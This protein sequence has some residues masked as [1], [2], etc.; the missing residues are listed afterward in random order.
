MIDF[1]VKTRSEIPKVIRKARRER[2]ISLGRAAAYIRRVYKT[3]VRGTKGGKPRPKGQPIRSRTGLVR[4]AVIYAV[5]KR[6]ERALIGPSFNVVG[7]SVA[8]HEHGLRYK[9]R[10]H[11]KRPTTPTVL[12]KSAPK[13]AEHWRTIL[14]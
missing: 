11:D 3:T 14:K 10:K 12:D 9:G 7:N 2:E 8:R 4:K 1:K 13:L 5:D 6:N